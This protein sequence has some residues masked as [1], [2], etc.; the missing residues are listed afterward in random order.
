M[1]LRDMMLAAAVSV[2]WGLAFVFTKF[3]LESFS[4]PQLTVLRFAIAAL[5]ALLLPRPQ[6]G[7]GLLVVTGLFLFAGQFLLLFF[8]YRAGMPPGLASIT[9]QMHVFFTVALA[10]VLLRERPSPR[11]GL[12]MAIAFA[13]LLALSGALSWAIG[14]LLLKRIGPVPVLPL[15]A[16]LSLV[17]PLPALALSLT[18]GDAP[19]LP[20]AILNASAIGLIST[21]YLGG[22]ATV[23]GYGI[24]SRLLTRYPA[25]AVAPF[26]LLAP[27][28]GVIASAIVFGERFAA[29]RYAGMA[30]ILLGLATIMLPSRRS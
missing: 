2:I 27:V 22:A 28:T 11:Q 18:L 14:N 3:G 4:A 5:P 19:S 10:G 20:A 26:V 9:Q 16:W 13:G 29:L 12:G 21:L 1:S 7:W 8:A 6:I 24:W 15:M 17:P 25:A 23:V 30:L